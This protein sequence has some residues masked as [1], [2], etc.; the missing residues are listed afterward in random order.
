M[1]KSG[2]F[3]LLKETPKIRDIETGKARLFLYFASEKSNFHIKLM[4]GLPIK[5]PSLLWSPNR[6]I[7]S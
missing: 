7:P 1:Y 5:L 2:F 4:L 6:K 3:L